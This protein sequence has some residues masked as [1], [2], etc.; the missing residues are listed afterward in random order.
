MSIE[1]MDKA[2]DPFNVLG[3]TRIKLTGEFKALFPLIHYDALC[4]ATPNFDESIFDAELDTPDFVIDS[5]QRRICIRLAWYVCNELLYGNLNGVFFNIGI[6]DGG[7]AI[8]GAVVD[9]KIIVLRIVFDQ[10]VHHALDVLCLVV[11]GND[12]QDPHAS[13]PPLLQT[14]M[15][16]AA[17]ASGDEA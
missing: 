12:R 4:K 2:I 5:M 6:G 3:V 10:I 14:W 15:A 13:L 9:D 8:L 17:M 11:G 7:S 16:T 1:A